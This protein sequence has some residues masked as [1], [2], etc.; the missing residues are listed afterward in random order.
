M[1]HFIDLRVFL[2]F[3]ECSLHAFAALCYVHKC[4]QFGQLE[5]LINK[6]SFTI[7]ILKSLSVQEG[8]HKMKLFE[9]NS[10]MAAS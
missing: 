3:G 6:C 2:A 1:Y 9:N 8:T 4:L 10:I 5:V 7:L